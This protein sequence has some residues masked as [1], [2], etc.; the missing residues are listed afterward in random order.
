MQFYFFLKMV[1]SPQDPSS[2]AKD[3]LE[4]PIRENL[5][6]KAPETNSTPRAKLSY[7]L[8][9]LKIL[10]LADV[11]NEIT[12]REH[13]KRNVAALGTGVAGGLLARRGYLALTNAKPHT[14]PPRADPR[15]RARRR[16]G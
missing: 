14:K 5:K 10:T 3:K 7:V 9:A 6:T 8:K 13:W 2:V 12:A 16:G 11:Y 1:G 15:A 4:E